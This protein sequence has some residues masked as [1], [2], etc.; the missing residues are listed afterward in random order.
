MYSMEVC[1]LG[2]R[3][4]QSSGPVVNDFFNTTTELLDLL[5]SGELDFILQRGPNRV[6]RYDRTVY[7]AFNT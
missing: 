4:D 5:N 3:G 6:P 2:F 7:W 1:C